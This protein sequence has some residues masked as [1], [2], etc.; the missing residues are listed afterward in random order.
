MSGFRPFDPNASGGGAGG[1]TYGAL[2]NVQ[3]LAIA[4]PSDLE[5]AF[6]TD[7]NVIYTF[8]MGS[9]YSPAGGVLV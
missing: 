9:W 3:I 5:N 2:T 4:S 8:Y 7:D 6:S 1:A